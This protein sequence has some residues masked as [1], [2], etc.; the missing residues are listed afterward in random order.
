V[1]NGA[2]SGASGSKTGMATA[3]P[4]PANANNGA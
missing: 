2:T 1:K 3:G 4:I